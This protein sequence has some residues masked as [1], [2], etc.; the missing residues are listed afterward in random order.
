MSQAMPIVRL[1]QPILVI[2]VIF[3]SHFCLGATLSAPA[4]GAAIPLPQGQMLCDDVGGG[5]VA[6]SSGTMVRPPS[7][8]GQ[9][10]RTTQIRVAPSL[11]ACTKSKDAVA[12]VVSGPIPAVDRRS[13]DLWVD[14]GRL[15]C[16]GTGIDGS[17]LEWDSK[18]EHGGDVCVAPS[19]ASAF[20]SCSYSVGKKM[21]ADPAYFVLRVLPA[22][23]SA[24]TDI[25]DSTG[26]SVTPDSLLITPARL[27]VASA[28][29]SDRHV[30]LSAGEARLP[31]THPEA[32]ATAECDA[33]Q[34]E[35][36]GRDVRV[37]SLS[38]PARALNLKLRLTPH[39]FVRSGD[40]FAQT[41]S[42]PLDVTYCPITVVSP[43]PIRDIDDV[44]VVI[45]V[46][47]RCGATAD[48]LRWKAN[49]ISVPVIDSE[50]KEDSVYMLVDIGR[51]TSEQLTLAATRGPSGSSIVALT[52]VPTVPAPQLRVALHLANFGDI[53]FIPSNRDV[54][55]SATAPNLHGTVVTLPVAG[56][57]VV[58]RHGDGTDIR[59]STGGGYVVLRFA[60]RDKSLPGR[61]AEA[62]LAHLNDFVQRALREVNVPAP[63]GAAASSKS[64]IVEMLCTQPTGHAKRVI[65]GVPLHIPFA[66]RDGCRLIIYRE[67]IPAEDG[68]QRLDI[69]V[70][71][72]TS[73]GVSRSEGHLEQRLVLHR[74][75]EQRVV[76]LH[77]V[78][79]QFDRITV[80]V[81][82]VI[83]ETQ[84]LRGGSEHLDVPAA[85]WTVVVEDTSL[86]FYA[87]AAIP[88]SLFR[89]SNDP[90]GAGTGPLSL[91]LGMLTRLT[92][93][94]SEG[95][96]GILALEG[97]VMGMGLATTST[98]QL[99]ILAGL[100]MGVP[101]GNVGQPTQASINIH[102][103]AAYRLGNE[104]APLLN[105]AGIPTGSYVA[106]KHWSFVFGPSVTFGN[107]GFDI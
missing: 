17:R 77:G 31:L 85:Q 97:G 93:V 5:W 32:V 60:I 42:I 88:V 15:E 104:T 71:V 36:I 3:E 78:K 106:L 72:T 99:N 37:L 107:L 67:R 10:G 21:P 4:G 11:A 19:T 82:H 38:G 84:Y 68:E 55:V 26:H 40:Q 98:R 81:T 16:R 62:D 22:G 18:G 105:F 87:T 102:A 27:L 54:T 74:G 24:H 45:R 2:G 7:D 73:A 83:D 39:V 12:L 70:D 9:I 34:C 23:V 90:G 1:L 65:P 20:Q 44:R 41:V 46:D 28:L 69:E 14:E 64:P 48:A 13:I 103:W 80:R 76:W 49:G 35:V 59:G 86:R 8:V 50:S 57:Y 101:V 52:T 75:S 63:F 61:F 47:A 58:I 89:F 94:T 100:G 51:V 53:D 29:T 6:E 43:P 56:A 92:W 91:N 96:D 95:R 25:Y 33:G 30:D 66:Q 79:S